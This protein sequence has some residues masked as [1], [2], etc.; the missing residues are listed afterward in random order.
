M[1]LRREWIAVVVFVFSLVAGCS[2]SSGMLAV[3]AGD[4]MTATGPPDTS[5]AIDANCDPSLT[6][7]SFGMDFFATYCNR[8]HAWTQ[9]GAQLSGN[10][11]A[12]IAGTSTGMPPSAPFPTPDQRMQLVNWIDCGAP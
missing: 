6:Y 10:A 11:I 7:A 5:P 1:V 9:E 8:C 4:D 12:D 3:D 2:S